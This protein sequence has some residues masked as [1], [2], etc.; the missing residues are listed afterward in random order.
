MEIYRSGSKAVVPFVGIADDNRI[1]RIGLREK[2]FRGKG[3]SRLLR[4]KSYT[5]QYSR[6]TK[7][8]RKPIEVISWLT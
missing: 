7:Q 6:M 5:S 2:Q 3:L 1:Y 4:Y 8:K